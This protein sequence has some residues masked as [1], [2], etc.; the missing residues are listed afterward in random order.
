MLV[1]P[2]LM[3]ALIQVHQITRQKTDLEL[4][5]KYNT[6]AIK[7]YKYPTKIKRQRGQSS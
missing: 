2:T 5:Q 6:T 7:N 4:Q 3:C 1:N